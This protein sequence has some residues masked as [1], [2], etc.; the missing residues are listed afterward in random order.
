MRR[1]R[2]DRARLYRSARYR[3]LV[4]RI[5]TNVRRMRKA[6][7]W[8]QEYAAEQCELAPRMFQAIEAGDVNA[9]LVTLARLAAGF[10]VDATQLFELQGRRK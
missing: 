10:G 8:T 6:L 7:D 2:A 3:E 5:A 4:E 9:T 1:R